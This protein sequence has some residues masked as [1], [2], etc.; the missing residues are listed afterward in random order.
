MK[1]IIWS[2]QITFFILVINFN[3]Y[4]QNNIGIISEI[5]IGSYKMSDLKKLN[6]EELSNLPFQAK[7]ISN[8]PNYVYYKISPE[9]QV[10]NLFSLGFSYSFNSTGSRI[11]RI[12]YSGEYLFDTR[13]QS[14]SYGIFCAFSKTIYYYF[15]VSIAGECGDIED[16]FSYNQLLQITDYKTTNQ[17]TYTSSNIY[18]EP[19]IKLSFKYSFIQTGFKI[20]YLYQFGSED[21]T[22]K[23]SQNFTIS[24]SDTKA[25]WQG[26]RY[27]VF[28]TLLYKIK[29]K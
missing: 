13:I 20:G 1:S 12:D 4:S 27:G 19:Q 23:K 3:I 11:S 7:I 15:I 24:G 9:L 2:C 26:L 8:Y 6:Q 18:F 21:L 17:D 29:N 28:L 10:N 22:D 25:E 5:G 16:K 14:N